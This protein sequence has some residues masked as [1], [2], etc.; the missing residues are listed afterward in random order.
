MEV[1][2]RMQ[3]GCSRKSW[4][5]CVRKDIGLSDEDVRSI[6]SG[7]RKKMQSIY[8]VHL[9]KWPLKRCFCVWKSN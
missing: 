2:G 5:D 6:I 8:P 3:R 9:E 4:W 7:K 1:D